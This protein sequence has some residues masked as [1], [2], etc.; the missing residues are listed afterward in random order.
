MWGVGGGCEGGRGGV[1][2][3]MAV[4]GLVWGGRFVGSLDLD[5]GGGGAEGGEGGS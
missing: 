2:D 1:R 3:M 5:L 4:V